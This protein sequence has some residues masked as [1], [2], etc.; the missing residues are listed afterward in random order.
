MIREWY[1]KGY[2][3]TQNTY[4]AYTSSL[5]NGNGSYM[6]IASSVS[7][8]RM[9]PKKDISTGEYPFEVGIASIPQVNPA[10]P[11]VIAQGPSLCIFEQEDPLEVVAS[12]L[13]VKFLTT[14]AE[15]QTEFS[16]ASGYMPVI[17]STV[18]NEAYAEYLASAD[19]GDHIAALS[20]K[21]CLEQEGAYFTAPAFNGS[22]IVSNEVGALLIRCLYE[23]TPD[24]DKLIEVA[25]EE[26][27][28]ECEYRIN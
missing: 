19:G 9:C 23:R 6:C 5:F 24:V 18:E 7:A 12:W 10:N 17:K 4:G 26:A 15:F 8:N 14:N 21:V 3:I 25:F 16:L 28:E 22:G 11:K 27:I 20:A 1:D 2:V 13:F